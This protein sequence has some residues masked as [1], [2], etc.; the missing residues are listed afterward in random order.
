MKDEFVRVALDVGSHGVRVMISYLEEGRPLEVIAL[1]D[2]QSRGF[3]NGAVVGIEQASAAIEEAIAEAEKIA[4][5][6]VHLVDVAVGSRQ[7]IAMNTQA[8]L[9][10]KSGKI[11]RQ[12]KIHAICQARDKGLE[13]RAC[14]HALVQTYV[15]D[16]HSGI[17][18]P[19][20]MAADA[21][22]AYVHV[23]SM[24]TWQRRNLLQCVQNAGVEVGR[25]VFKGVAVSYAALTPAERDLGVC[26]VDIGADTM[27]YTVWR[28]NCPLY[29]NVVELGGEIIS[30]ELAL[31][32]KTPRQFAEALKIEKG[33]ALAALLQEHM[34][35]ISSVG[36]RDNRLVEAQEVVDCIASGYV[37]MLKYLRYDLEQ[38]G[39]YHLLPAGFVFCGGAVQM[40]G[41]EQL[42]R[43]FLQT[44]VR[45]A[46]P[47][48]IHGLPEFW[49]GNPALHTV[50]GI[51][52][53][54]AQPL[55]NYALENSKKHSIITRF[56]DFMRAL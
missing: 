25:L 2:A 40:R 54:Q 18:D 55:E 39:F 4:R 36:L 46:Y 43:D 29:S 51:A 47:E 6:K 24:E 7:T 33:V 56:K 50:L 28:A 12:E 16:E 49:Q 20:G 11:S 48:K 15:V 27:T 52:A 5:L 26:V 35:E 42:A 13:G 9:A 37:K 8:H 22:E 10:I 44:P 41:F 31:T 3:K 14:V 38:A 17:V 1:G 23:V 19:V 53:L 21:L 30:S 45:V 32:L 34:L